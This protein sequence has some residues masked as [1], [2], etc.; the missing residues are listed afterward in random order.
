MMIAG[1][2]G[3]DRDG[4]ILSEEAF[5][6]DARGQALVDAAYIVLGYRRA[7]RGGSWYV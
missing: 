2:W 3:G 4:V 1:A 5:G 7:E 6:L